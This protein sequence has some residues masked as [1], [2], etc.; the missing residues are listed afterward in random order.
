METKNITVRVPA[1]LYDKMQQRAN[2][3][4][5]SAGSINQ[6]IVDALRR[7]EMLRRVSTAELR[8]KFT[9]CE[10]KCL[11]DLLNGTLAEG[12]FRYDAGA[13]AAEVADGEAYDGTCAK[14]GVD[15]DALAGKCGGLTAAQVEAL[16]ARVETFWA[17]PEADLDAWA[18]Y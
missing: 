14:W 2:D 1:D 6:Q 16:Y 5:G 12:A 7:A 3:P 4:A 15:K 8:G 9:A 10:W 17:H 18:E 13:L 11:A